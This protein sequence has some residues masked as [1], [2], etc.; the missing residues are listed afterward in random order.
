MKTKSNQT[1]KKI[2]TTE[3]YLFL[4]LIMIMLFLAVFAKGFYDT[5]NIMSLL[6]RFSYTLIA[7]IGMNMIIITSNIDVSAGALISVLC[8]AAAAIGS[9]GADIWI[10]LPV[11]MLLGGVLSLANGLF[12]TKMR[13]P[14]IVATLA[15]TQLF[16][17]I[18]PLLVG[19]SI[20]DL[21]ANFTWLAY[22][23]KI[24]SVLPASVVIMAVV[25]VIFLLFMK[26]SK[27]SKKLYA[28][29]NNK[30]GARLAGVNVDRVIV[31][32]YVL[33]GMLYG[34]T[35]I[36]IATASQR[37]MPTM[38]N[39][40]EMTFIAAVVLGGTSTMG[41]SGKLIGTVVGAFILSLVTPAINYL[42]IS[43]DWSDAIMGGIIIIS[44]VFSAINIK[45]K[46]RI[47]DKGKG[48]QK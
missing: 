21:P 27:F 22:D 16:Q 3:F 12:I 35:A 13:I 33:A 11:T 29:G 8:V 48:E 26:Y 47:A 43:P 23:A 1:W 4:L 32:A 37:V 44:V 40:E 36:I 9:K 15:T 39:G 25:T 7:A 5:N 18:L 19:G 31:T 17:G 42:G 38:A 2:L 41:G 34:I 20:Y 10:F 45:K 14:A 6:N 46:R 28:I 24:F 30:E